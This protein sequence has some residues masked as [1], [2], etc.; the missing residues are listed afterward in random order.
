MFKLAFFMFIMT[1]WALAASALYVVRSPDGFAV[2]TKESLTFTDTYADTR[3]W[4]RKDVADH[5]EVVARLIRTEKAGMLAHILGN[6][7]ASDVKDQLSD[8]LEKTPERTKL[9]GKAR[10]DADTS[11]TRKSGM[12][13]GELVDLVTGS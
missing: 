12:T 11:K 8:A 10:A 1:G 2:V 3:T 9:W 6:A 4:E 5:R 13:A 7:K